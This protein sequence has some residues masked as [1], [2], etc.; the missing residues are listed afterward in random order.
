MT[1]KTDLYISLDRTKALADQPAMGHNRWHPDIPPIARVDEGQII[2]LE[3]RDAFDGQIRPS[4]T[5]EEAGRFKASRTHPMTGPIW[6]NG[7]DPGDLLEVHIH[8]VEAQDFGFTL[9]GATFGFL[10]D[11]FS[12][13]H[14]IR[15]KIE[16]GFATSDELPMVRLPGAPFMGVMGVA[17]SHELLRRI[18]RREADLCERGGAVMLPDATDAIPTNPRI[19]SE[20]LKSLPP[21]EFAG[22]LDIKHLTAGAKLRIPVYV[23]GALFSAGDGHFAQGDNECCTA[24]EM[25]ATLY[26]SFRVLKK[27]ALR[28]NINHVE[29]YR[30]DYY[31]TP[32]L[33]APKRFY[34]AS[35]ICVSEDGTNLSENLNLAARNALLHIIDYM[36][37]EHGVTRQ[38]AYAICSV[39]VDLRINEAV[40]VPNCLVSAYLPLDIFGI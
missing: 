25:G 28:R 11:I 4:T 14:L 17:P 10:R 29:F 18:T 2:A 31:T 37:E 39:A 8:K 16:S 5:I 27:A 6:I 9:Q 23:L 3:T 34:A 15:W 35:G 22:N 7:A 30:D 21:R 19:A 33:S 13:T 24:V 36:V 12:D 38:Q 40:N 1:I 26:C 20:G 32:E